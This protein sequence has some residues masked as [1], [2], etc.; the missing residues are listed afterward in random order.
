[1]API[2]TGTSLRTVERIG[3]K[4]LDYPEGALLSPTQK[5]KT[6]KKKGS[7]ENLEMNVIRQTMEDL[8]TQSQRTRFLRIPKHTMTAHV[9]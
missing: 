7:M 9:Y 8:Y 5:K 2:C 6:T 1:M 4:R 3:K